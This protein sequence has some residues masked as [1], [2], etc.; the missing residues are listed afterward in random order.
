M[1]ISASDVKALREK[2]G[3]GMMDCKKALEETQGD[4]AAA[5]K[6]LKEKGL[7]A[8]E[9]RAGRATN[10]GKIFIK[11]DGAQGEAKKAVIAEIASETDFVARNPDF[12]TLGAELTARALEK[13]YT[14]A[15]EELS[16]MVTD[17]ATKIRENMNLKRLSM[18]C[19]E[20]KQALTSY[21]HGDG[22]IGVIVKMAADKAGIVD[23][24]EI[25]EL[26]FNLALHIAAFSPLYLNRD[27]VDQAWIKEQ[28]E[29]FTTQLQ[30]DEA[31]KSKPENVQKGIIQ[32]RVNKLLKESCL[33][34]QPYVKDEKFTVSQI[35]AETGKKLGAVL[36]IADYTYF[37]VG[38]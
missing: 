38:A 20:D 7:A 24:A 26:A 37:K 15:N 1:A 27:K 30:Q 5:E 32:G 19:T 36:S 25:K 12:I 10:E 21:L 28:E 16:Q 6:L 29:I 31:M 34:D 4:A 2:T 14:E 18:I 9:K 33:M 8:V 23:S 35:L 17:L 13:G 3:A 11:L 22:A